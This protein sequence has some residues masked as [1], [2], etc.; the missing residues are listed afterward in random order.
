MLAIRLTHCLRGL[1]LLLLLAFAACQT[2]PPVQEMSDARQA[3]MAARDAGAAEKATRDLNEAI[4]HL[5]SAEQ[6]LE[7]KE[8]HRARRDALAAKDSALTALRL[9]ETETD[10]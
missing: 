6:A 3:I 10:N 5:D 4:G 2:A 7:R 1:P 8:Y 9:S